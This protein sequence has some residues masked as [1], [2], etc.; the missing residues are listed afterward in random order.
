MLR[1]LMSKFTTHNVTQ[2]SESEIDI[3]FYI[4]AALTD[5]IGKFMEPKMLNVAILSQRILQ[6]SGISDGWR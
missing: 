2:I 4:T 5:V 6:A 1:N 3:D